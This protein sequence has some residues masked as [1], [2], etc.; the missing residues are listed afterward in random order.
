MKITIESG[1]R[2]NSIFLGDEETEGGFIDVVVSE[3][4]MTAGGS[5]SIDELFSALQAFIQK[6]EMNREREKDL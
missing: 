2:D 5:F 3:K 1:E 6:R 4:T